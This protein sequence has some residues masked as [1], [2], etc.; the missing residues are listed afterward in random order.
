MIVLEYLKYFTLK[1]YLS[2]PKQIKNKLAF[3]IRMQSA[4]IHENTFGRIHS[5]QRE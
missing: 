1:N 4:N 5:D 2:P 3:H